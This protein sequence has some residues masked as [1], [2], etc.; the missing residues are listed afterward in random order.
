MIKS[1][2]PILPMFS[3]ANMEKRSGKA[4]RFESIFESAIAIL[5]N[6]LPILEEDYREDPIPI[7]SWSHPQTEPPFGSYDLEPRPVEEM[8]RDESLPLIDNFAF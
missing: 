5:D 8:L 4:R 3:D 1:R 2:L 7:E 6:D